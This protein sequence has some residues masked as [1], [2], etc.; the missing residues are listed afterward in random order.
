MAAPC[1]PQRCGLCLFE[2]QRND[3]I[4]ASKLIKS[5]SIHDMIWLS[6]IVTEDDRQSGEMPYYLSMYDNF[7]A[8]FQQ[9]IGACSHHNGQAIGCHI[10]C[11]DSVPE[12]LRTSF[13]KALAYQYEPS[14]ADTTKRIRW[15]Y[16]QWAS[17]T[18]L[19]YTKPHLPQELCLEIARHL[20]QGPILHRYAATL[21]CTL[22]KGMEYRDSQISITAG[23][24]A[25]FTVFEGV[26]YISSLS[27]TC[28]KYHTERLSTPFPS[29]SIDIIYIAENYLGVIQVLFGNST[30][31]I[32]SVERRQG[33]WW[34]IVR[35]CER[36]SMLVF[37]TDVRCRIPS[38][39]QI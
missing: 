32:P 10:T 16:S 12:L 34:R 30:L 29:Q 2:L 25:S 11:G 5:R 4:F 31:Q 36:E 9:C 8:H 3:K 26:R 27:N 20:L 6:G 14:P 24:W 15:I 38:A 23:I 33:L 19:R 37:Q 17:T 35:L 18:I 28:D 39:L 7:G 13:L 1:I 21:A 22:V